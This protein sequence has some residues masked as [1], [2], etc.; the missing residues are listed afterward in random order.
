MQVGRP[1]TKCSRRG[2]AQQLAVQL[3]PIT[4]FIAMG[5]IRAMQPLGSKELLKTEGTLQ[6]P[7]RCANVDILAMTMLVVPL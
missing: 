1:R 7:M 5:Q 2:S 4:Q 6:G 3:Q